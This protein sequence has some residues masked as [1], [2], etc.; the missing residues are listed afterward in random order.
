FG[1]GE[2]SA[3]IDL[4][5]ETDGERRSFRKAPLSALTENGWTAAYR[6]PNGVGFEKLASFRSIDLALLQTLECRCFGKERTLASHPTVLRFR[7]SSG[8][9][10]EVSAAIERDG[11]PR[12]LEPSLVVG[13]LVT[14]E[15]SVAGTF[16]A[17]NPGRCAGRLSVTVLVDPG[18]R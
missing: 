7:W 18:I 2:G 4:E 13:R 12:G 8:K 1:A 10:P 15:F 16:P 3:R 9:L 6:T 14:Y 17:G 5:Y 11:E